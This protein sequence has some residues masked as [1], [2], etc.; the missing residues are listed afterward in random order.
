MTL[1][2]LNNFPLNQLLSTVILKVLQTIRRRLLLPLQ[3]FLAVFAL[4]VWWGLPRIERDLTNRATSLLREMKLEKRVRVIRFD[5][6]VATL[7]GSLPDAN[8]RADLIQRLESMESLWGLR[9]SNPQA[10]QII[11]P[12]IP[13]SYRLDFANREIKLTGNVPGELEKK[14]LNRKV[15]ILFPKSTV[16][17]MS[18]IVSNTDVATMS[19]NLLEHLP[20]LQENRQLRWV[21]VD[22][23]QLTVS[24]N[25]PSEEARQTFIDSLAAIG[26]HA[27]AG[28]I[29][30]ISPPQMELKFSQNSLI[31]MSGRLASAEDQQIAQ[32]FLKSLFPKMKVAGSFE[33]EETLGPVEWVFAKLEPLP[34]LQKLGKLTLCSVAD[35]LPI[36]EAETP[37]ASSRISLLA[38]IEAAYDKK[39]KARVSIAQPLVKTTEVSALWA[40]MGEDSTLVA[41]TVANESE[42]T[43][44]MEKLST[45]FPK[46]TFKPNI[47]LKPKLA[48]ARLYLSLLDPLTDISNIDPNFYLKAF[49]L[50]EGRLKV[51]GIVPDEVTRDRLTG[52]ILRQY[53]GRV[54]AQLEVDPA[55]Q[56]SPDAHWSVTFRPG[57]MTVKGQVVSKSLGNALAADLTEAYPGMR[58]ENSLE[59][60]PG[61]LRPGN[62]KELLAGLTLVAAP[63]Q[64]VQVVWH[65]D[66]LALSALTPTEESKASMEARLGSIYGKMIDT[67]IEVVSDSAL[68]DKPAVTLVD[69]TLR[70][71]AGQDDYVSA[72]LPI[73]QRV[74]DLMLIH[75]DLEI[76]IDSHTDAKGTFNANLNTSQNRANTIA[77]WLGRRGI[78]AERIKARGFGSRKPVAD[79]KTEA[80]RDV[81]RRIEFHVLPVPTTTSP[82][83]PP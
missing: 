6:P 60:T 4:G 42:A 44:F 82:P 46:M 18:T 38:A 83:L 57:T 77:K 9:V 29:H 40:E 23:G 54:S 3:F 31:T 30:I 7:T 48:G 39:V 26:T 53:S 79:M 21:A 12:S 10:I 20:D 66:R 72:N 68:A 33:I 37:N 32:N 24:A 73:L 74:L 49:G 16:A 81:N 5:G 50:V 70:I 55:F 75:P 71:R 41:L 8:L 27:H 13:V 67:Q 28:D 1:P 47:T 58:M 76:S 56:L 36:V 35:S 11:P 51:Q 65:Q 34:S 19:L 59:I 63:E 25:L 52:L 14:S 78:A 22:D 62:W 80:G 2:T 43:L 17:D 69:C 45:L 61:G 15:R 64:T